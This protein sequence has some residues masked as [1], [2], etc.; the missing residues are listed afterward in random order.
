MKV[1]ILGSKG[2]LGTALKNLFEQKKIS[3]DGVDL[4]DFDITNKDNLFETIEKSK[5]DIIINSAAYTNVKSAEK[6]FEKAVSINAIALKSL[7]EICNK[8]NI[9]LCHISTDYVFDG[10][11]REPYIE[12]DRTNPL[13]C[14][15]LSKELGEKIIKNYCKDFVIVRTAALYGNSKL[16]SENVVDKIVQ[17][18]QSNN[19]ISLVTDEFTTPTY[20]V[21]LA[22][23]IY[24]ILR[25]KISGIVHAT[26][27]GECNW[28]EFGEF[29]FKTLE[30]K[31]RIKSVNSR[32]YSKDLKKPIY[33]VL[34]NSRLKEMNK[35]IMPHWK[36]SLEKYLNK[37]Y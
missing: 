24:Q 12:E 2:Q 6:E 5:S 23:Q 36:I 30:I 16:K 7:A 27:E 18:A 21:D 31:V 20:A 35:N 29:I 9:S 26:C 32:S 25:S 15:G 1:L 34:E 13:N 33:S 28:K 8:E 22:Q 4:P 19:E 37:N 14:Y 11:M 17:F 10:T 3:Y